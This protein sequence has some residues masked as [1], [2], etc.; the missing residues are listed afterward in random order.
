MSK[1]TL[2]LSRKAGERIFIGDVEV[3][4]ASAEAGRVRLAIKADEIV[5]IS[6][7]RPPVE[8]TALDTVSA[9]R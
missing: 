4:V 6:R 1:T 7:D 2:V 3:Y 8:K 5:R 9:V